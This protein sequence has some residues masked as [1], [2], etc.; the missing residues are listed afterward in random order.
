MKFRR[1]MP[2]LQPCLTRTS[3]LLLLSRKPQLL[4]PE[5]PTNHDWSYYNNNN[6]TER[7]SEGEGAVTKRSASNRDE[8]ACKDS[9][10]KYINVSLY[11]VFMKNFPNPQQTNPTSKY[12]CKR[13]SKFSKQ[14]ECTVTL[15]GWPFLSDHSSQVLCWEGSGGKI[16]EIVGIPE[17]PV[18]QF[19]ML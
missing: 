5:R 15:I 12:R 10:L 11:R 8:A 17:H 7:E 19:I 16:L 4:A 3:H 2:P 13:F 9:P 1:Q 18:Y 6:R 14:Y